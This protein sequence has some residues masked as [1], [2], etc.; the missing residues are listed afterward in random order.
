[1]D[2]WDGSDG[3]GGDNTGTGTPRLAAAGTFY[4]DKSGEVTIS[5]GEAASFLDQPGRMLRSRELQ[6]GPVVDVL[7]IVTDRAMCRVAGL[8][9]GCVY[10]EENR[11]RVEDKIVLANQQFVGGPVTF[12][13]V[14]IIQ[15]A[16]G[17]DADPDVPALNVLRNDPSVIGWRNQ[18]GADLV[19][20]LTGSI[21]ADSNTA[22]IA[23]LN[24]PESV[25][26]VDH[27]STYTYT[28]ELGKSS[29][30]MEVLSQ[31]SPNMVE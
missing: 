24:S 11:L 25:T 9:G 5:T 8:A 1:M 26:S 2:G 14:Q 15:I 3:G 10:T 18:Y 22:G 30:C 4:P 7:V 21:P 17:Y 12:R 23:Y 6:G 27:M 28:H 19:A 16:A 31:T 13:I 20:M 29:V